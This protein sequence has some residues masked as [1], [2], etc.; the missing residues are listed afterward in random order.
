MKISNYKKFLEEVNLSLDILKKPAKQDSAGPLRGDI[1]IKKIK[2]GEEI[3]TKDDEEVEIG[4]QDDEGKN[5]IK[6]ITTGGKYDADKAADYLKRGTRYKYKFVDDE[7]KSYR[8]SDFVKVKDFGGESSGSSLGTKAT[9][10]VESIQTIVFG[11]KQYMDAQSIKYFTHVDIENAIDWWVDENSDAEKFVKIPTSITKSTLNSYEAYIPTFIKTA[12]FFINHKDEIKSGDISLNT[13]DGKKHRKT[14]VFYQI[15][16]IGDFMNILNETYKRCVKQT[17]KE[18]N[19]NDK[20]TIPRSNT[21]NISKWTPSDVWAVN[22]SKEES[23]KSLLK[24]ADSMLTLNLLIDELFDKRDLVGL[25]LKKIGDS[26][27]KRFPIIIN[28]ESKRPIYKFLD[29]TLSPNPFTKNTKVTLRRYFLE[30]DSATERLLPS[31]FEDV[32]IRSTSSSVANINLEVVGA[33]S[34][35]G[36]V[37]LETINHILRNEDLAVIED[38]KSIESSHPGTDGYDDLISEVGLLDSY[39][40]KKHSREDILDIERSA[41][42][43][44]L[45]EI[46]GRKPTATDIRKNKA[47]LISKYQA[48]SLVKV[49]IE[50]GDKKAV[51]RAINSI[52]YHALSI[53]NRYFMCPKYARVIEYI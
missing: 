28:K 6:N 16:H 26:V 17:I 27:G 37:S 22:I 10:F 46:K 48:L 23:I 36:K 25:S 24:E 44:N 33:S 53:Q 2:D 34:R 32:S 39:L 3:K 35:H 42:D 41:D 49:F 21:V 40:K 45:I 30:T 15:S 12:N 1:L 4:K 43:K 52:M 29:A 50:S 5:L 47:S 7:D 8:L 13:V 9:R 20:E 14:Y 19:A 51:N 11:Y 31:G 38:A 18:E